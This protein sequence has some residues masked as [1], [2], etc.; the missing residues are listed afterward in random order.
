MQAKKLPGAARLMCWRETPESQKTRLN[1]I[2]PASSEACGQIDESRECSRA[3]LTTRRSHAC[4]LGN[5]AA[6]GKKNAGPLCLALLA[7]SPWRNRRA[8][9][10]ADSDLDAAIELATAGIGI[11]SHCKCFPIAFGCDPSRIDSSPS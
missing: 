2:D 4:Q 9:F 8:I 6:P 3:G 5:A 10:A 11:A 1:A 7:G